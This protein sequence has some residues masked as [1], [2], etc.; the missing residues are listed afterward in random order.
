MRLCE[1]D[2]RERL[3]VGVGLSESRRRRTLFGLY[4]V[5]F[6][7]GDCG[8]WTLSSCRLALYGLKEQRG[9]DFSQNIYALHEDEVSQR[10]GPAAAAAI[11]AHPCDHLREAPAGGAK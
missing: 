4:H 2:E 11:F 7:W 1:E 6:L 9:V 10:A 8:H 3:K 5:T